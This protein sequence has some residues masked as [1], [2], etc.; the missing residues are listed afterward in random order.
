LF[1]QL[2]RLFL[3][4]VGSGKVIMPV[5]NTCCPAPLA[6]CNTMPALFLIPANDGFKF[7]LFCIVNAQL[8]QDVSV[9][10]D[11]LRLVCA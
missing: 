1:V 9:A 10:Q 8:A 3:P 2:L 5:L 11:V 6:L 7:A 4:L